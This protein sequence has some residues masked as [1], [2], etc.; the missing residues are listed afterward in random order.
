MDHSGC[1]C[2]GLSEIP[3]GELYTCGCGLKWMGFDSSTVY[4]DPDGDYKDWAAA[5]SLAVEETAMGL[6]VESLLPDGDAC[7][8]AFS[9][10]FVAGAVPVTDA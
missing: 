8:R 1:T 5:K 9:R 10:E 3:H 7:P 2:D 6:D 4:C